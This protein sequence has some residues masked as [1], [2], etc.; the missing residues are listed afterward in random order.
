MSGKRQFPAVK[1]SQAM[2]WLCGK[3]AAISPNTQSSPWFG[4]GL[5]FILIVRSGKSAPLRLRSTSNPEQGTF[6][7]PSYLLPNM[8]C[9]I[10]RR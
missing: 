6:W 7:S 4:L 9:W 1:V 10:D 3:T 8:I 5:S 2:Y